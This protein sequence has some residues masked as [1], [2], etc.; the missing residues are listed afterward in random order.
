MAAKRAHDQVASAPLAERHT[1]EAVLDGD[2]ADQLAVEEM[3][4]FM[5]R[6]PHSSVQGRSS[7]RCVHLLG[8][9]VDALS[10][11]HPDITP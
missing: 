1:G 11:R 6:S 7:D 5:K 4:R 8:E 2:A 3:A 10:D 9:V